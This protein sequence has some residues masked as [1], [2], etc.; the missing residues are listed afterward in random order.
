[1]LDGMSSQ[2]GQDSGN[3]FRPERR[4]K[5]KQALVPV[6]T[7]YRILDT[8]LWFTGTL[9]TLALVLGYQQ[10]PELLRSNPLFWIALGLQGPV[11]L[12][13]MCRGWPFVLRYGILVTAICTYTIM[14]TMV[15]GML[16]NMVFFVI[17]AV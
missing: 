16:P 17:V 7:C 3:W 10:A 9:A 13:A 14:V 12:A 11:L 4:W 1:M 5:G 2:A 8:F 15:A 6:E